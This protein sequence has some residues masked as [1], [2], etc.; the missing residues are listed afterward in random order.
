MK[1]LI[2]NTSSFEC[3]LNDFKTVLVLYRFDLKSECNYTKGIEF[4][5][6]K[7]LGFE[8]KGMTENVYEYFD[9]NYYIYYTYYVY[10]PWNVRNVTGMNKCYTNQ[11]FLRWI[12]KT[13]FKGKSINE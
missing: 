1:D 12:Y 2:M 5:M 8:C 11:D 7:F 4:F 13:Y 9:G 10:F 3:W 6:Q